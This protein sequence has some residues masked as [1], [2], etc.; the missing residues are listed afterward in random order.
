MTVKKQLEQSQG[1]EGNLVCWSRH[2]RIGTSGQIVHPIET[3]EPRKV[4]QGVERNTVFGWTGT[5]SSSSWPLYFLG[6]CLNL[7]TEDRG[8]NKTKACITRQIC[9][10]FGDLGG[11]TYPQYLCRA[12]WGKQSNAALADLGAIAPKTKGTGQTCTTSNINVVWAR[13]LLK[14]VDMVVT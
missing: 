12:P 3:D 11:S 9:M 2:D 8:R 14:E 1:H 4:N 10:V 7:Y 13:S 6:S 5:S